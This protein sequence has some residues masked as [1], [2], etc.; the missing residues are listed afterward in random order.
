MI[1]GLTNG[2]EAKRF[3]D[4]ISIFRPLKFAFVKEVSKPVEGV[5]VVRYHLLVSQ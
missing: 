2:R 5:G 4:R 3:C 1:C